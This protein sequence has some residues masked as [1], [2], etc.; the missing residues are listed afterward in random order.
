MTDFPLR[1]AAIAES[2]A[3]YE[4]HFIG[5]QEMTVVRQDPRN[6]ALNPMPDAETEVMDIRKVIMQARQAKGMNYEIAPQVQ[7]M[8]IELPMCL[9]E[10][11]TCLSDLTKIQDG[12]LK[13]FDVLLVWDDVEVSEPI[14]SNYPV[15]IG[16]PIVPLLVQR[17]STDRWLET[18]GRVSHHRASSYPERRYA[19]SNHL[20]DGHA[21]IRNQR[22]FSQI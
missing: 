16:P 9:V 22:A 1:A 5:L 3:A 14:R 6:F 7:N 10:P 4:P 15:V 18:G 12:R 8:D 20:Y 2:I 11:S 17:G 21:Q 19:S 13:M